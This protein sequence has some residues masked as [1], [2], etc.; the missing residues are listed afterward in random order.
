M[1]SNNW[2]DGD[3]QGPDPHGV[4]PLNPQGPPQGFHPMP[5]QAQGMPQR[6]MQGPPP[7]VTPMPPMPQGQP[8]GPPP[9][10][11]QAQGVPQRPPM[12]PAGGMGA[13]MPPGAPGGQNPP[14][15]RYGNYGVPSGQGGSV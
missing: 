4:R 6:G 5:S 12:P 7:Q 3:M 2:H 11:P 10:P 8:Q 14:R 1:F 13:G 15:P 9:M